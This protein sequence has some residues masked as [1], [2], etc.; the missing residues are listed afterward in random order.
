MPPCGAEGA[1]RRRRRSARFLFSELVGLD[2]GEDVIRSCL[3]GSGG[4]AR[5]DPL[6]DQPTSCEKRNR[7]IASSSRAP[8]APRRHP[9]QLQQMTVNV[10]RHGLLQS[11]GLPACGVAEIQPPRSTSASAMRRRR[12]RLWA[13]FGPTCL[14]DQGAIRAWASSD[15]QRPKKRQAVLLTHIFTPTPSFLIRDRLLDQKDQRRPLRHSS[16]FPSPSACS[17]LCRSDKLTLKRNTLQGPALSYFNSGC[18]APAVPGLSSAALASF[19]FAEGF[20]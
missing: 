3:R 8:S 17:W 16:R 11:K 2:L 18:P 20:P 15:L 9:A 19:D 4:V 14:P 7:A 6:P 12:D 10:N 5:H 1:R 13:V